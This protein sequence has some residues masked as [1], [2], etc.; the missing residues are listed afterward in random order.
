MKCPTCG[1]ILGNRQIY[2]E[3]KLLEISSNPNISE[4]D[5]LKQKSDLVLSLGLK[6]N[7]CRSRVQTFK[8]KPATIK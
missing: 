1:T 5:K 3:A 4:E 2:Y 7:C 6:R 8:S